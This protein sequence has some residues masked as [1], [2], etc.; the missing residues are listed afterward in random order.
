MLEKETREFID[1]KLKKFGRDVSYHRQ[2][3]AEFPIDKN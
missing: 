1:A 2:V 3:I